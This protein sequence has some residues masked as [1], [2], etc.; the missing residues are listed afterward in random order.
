MAAIVPFDCALNRELS[1]LAFNLRVL[2]EAELPEPSP[3]LAA[4][5]CNRLRAPASV[6]P[7]VQQLPLGPEVAFSLGKAL[8]PDLAE[9]LAGPR[10]K[11]VAV[12]WAEGDIA[13]RI[14]EQPRLIRTP[15]E[16][17]S[18]LVRLLEQAADDPQV[19]AIRITLYRLVANSR[20]AQ[21]LARAA[22]QGKDV[23]CLLELRARFDEE[24]NI[25]YAELLQEAGCT[26]LYGLPNCK[27]HA[28]VCLILYGTP[29][30]EELR[31]ITQIGTG[32][33]NEKTAALYTDLAYLTADPLIAED[34]LALFRALCR[35]EHAHNPK[36][37]WIA[38]ES[39][40][41]R[42][43][44]ELDAEIAQA[45]AGRPAAVFLKVNGLNSLPVMAKL[46]A[47]S[48]AGVKVELFVRGICCLR[49]GI[50]G[51]TEHITVRS[52]V[53]DHLE[54]SRILAFG[55]PGRERLFI[56]SGDLLNRNLTRRVEVYVP[57][58]DEPTRRELLATIRMLRQDNAK[59]RVMAPSGEYALPAATGLWLS[60]QA[61]LR[62]RAAAQNAAP[63]QTARR[64]GLLARLLGACR[65]VR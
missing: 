17:I 27:V 62:E 7:T 20:I 3:E 11:P 14:R 23:L 24:S 40:L 29:G 31:A 65:L 42:L 28:K 36:R 10:R 18:P 35:G 51:K 5:L 43:L 33:Y 45:R 16:S 30:R 44:A 53:G 50:P 55:A 39:V 38:P 47:C 49:P 21:A 8:P 9:A 61:L 12:A 22:E 4:M 59:A 41:E 37:L 26:V 32:N 2:E 57:I 56:G 34:A 6:T 46:I 54:H 58:L 19:S 1:W 64:P 13:A 25:N 63:R 48:Q 15:F 60:A 52:I